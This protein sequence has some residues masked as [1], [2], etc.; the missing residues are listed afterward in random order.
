MDMG[1]GGY[2]DDSA[3]TGSGLQFGGNFG[4]TFLKK[5]A[6]TNQGGKGGTQADALDIVFEIAGTEKGYRLFPVTKVFGKNNSGELTDKN[7]KEYKEAR[8]AAQA[9][10]K[11]KVIHILK[12]F[13]SEDD[14]KTAVSRPFSGFPEYAQV[15]S[16]LLPRDFDKKPLDIFLQYQYNIT[17][18]N[19]VTFLEIPRKLN[20]GAFLVAAVAPQGVWK[21][22]IDAEG[23]LSYVD[24]AGNIHPFTRSAWFM[25]QPYANQKK[26]DSQAGSGGNT[27]QPI[28]TQGTGT[29]DSGW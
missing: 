4:K 7:S 9:E 17:G 16:A 14:I 8:A 20:Q 12:A 25:Q 10:L 29:S 15:V 13:I 18:D 5:F 26:D 1:Y 3:S 2:V 22:T 23:G 24:E 6:Y 11:Q 28:G 21:K 27:S 19:K